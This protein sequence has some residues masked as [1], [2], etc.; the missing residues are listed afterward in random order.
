MYQSFYNLNAKPFQIT[1]DPKFL[2][3]G[4]KHSEALAT[5][6]YGI[7]ENKGFLLLTGDIGTGKTALINQLVRMI[8]VAAIVATIPDPGLNTMDFFNFLALEFEMDGKFASKG[9]F[10]I[11]LKQFLLTA[12]SAQKKVLLIVDE[13]Q[14]LNHELLEQIRLLSNIEL[15]NRKLINIFFVG[16]T[17]FNQM[18]LEERNK[19]VR[20]RITANY[21]IEPLD[22]KETG[23]Y[24][25]HRLSVAGATRDI[26]TDDAILAV[27]HFSSGYPRL[28]NIL[29]DHALLTG[30]SA[31]MES[32]D[33]D[34]IKECERELRIPINK[35]KAGRREAGS[36][37]LQSA[38]G[39][40]DSAA[41]G[42]SPRARK[43]A[44]GII[45]MLLL[46]FT[47]Y[48]VYESQQ[49][50]NPRWKM[51]DIAP[52]TYEGLTGKDSVKLPTATE[53]DSGQ[54]PVDSNADKKVDATDSGQIASATPESTPV[55]KETAAAD[56][57][58]PVD[59]D[60]SADPF[61]KKP[62][63]I[64]FQHNSN[65]VTNEGFDILNRVAEFLAYKPETRIS[66][67]GYTD[68]TGPRSYN[69]SVS[70]FRANAIKSYLVGKGVAA[71]NITATGMGPDKPIA[72][73]STAEGREKNRR[74]EIEMDLGS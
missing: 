45:F 23:K 62:L 16:Q 72:P 28:I 74:V 46:L 11:Q 61:T 56:E 71:G 6:K 38:A 32:I 33:V 24:I 73:N 42:S 29:C 7:L 13:A 47:S 41:G 35:E 48:L 49:T 37:P 60:L 22:A 51:E 59:D 52:Q 58:L 17:E 57:K 3:M 12:E 9:D 70:Q 4:E 55:Q 36:A 68:S 21:H 5:L 50:G 1:S 64:Y 43:L 20:Q 67:K 19:A 30:Y 40:V 18:L 27:H 63:I 66:V 54:M 69:L 8:D 25:R 26:F 53:N 44:I 10:L 15:D 39:S 2:W 34:T 65:E 31:S 14:R